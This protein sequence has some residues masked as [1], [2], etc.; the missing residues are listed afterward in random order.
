MQSGVGW[1]DCEHSVSMSIQCLKT[2]FLNAGISE[3]AKLTIRT[4]FS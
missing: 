2:I 1:G 4:G 3:V